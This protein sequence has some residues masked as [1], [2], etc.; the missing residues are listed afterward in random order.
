MVSRASA[1]VTGGAGFIGSHLVERLAGLGLR[2]AVAD[3]LSTGKRENLPTQAKFYPAS[4]T[5]PDLDRV[6]EAEKPSIV[7]HNAAQISVSVS[8]R[9]PAKD[10]ETNVLGILRVLELCRRYKVEKLVFSST[11]GALY[12][13]P[14]YLPCDEGHPINA[15]SPYGTSKYA[16]EQYMELYGRIH[17]LK[18]VALR[19]GN[20]YGPRQDPHG[21]AGVVAIFA[22]M[23]LAG[24]QPTIF[25]DGLQERDFVYVDDV[26]EANIL[27]MKPGI[28][29]HYNI[30]TGNGVNVNRV[31]KILSAALGYKSEA[32]Y[33]PPRPGDVYKI[34][35]DAS[36]ARRELG[37]SPK[38]GIDDGLRRTAD[39]FRKAV[40]VQARV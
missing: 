39:F 29:G 16:G 19:Y 13:E 22:S 6:F 33:G 10:A 37:W 25:G 18:S 9:E 1:L 27:A 23:M 32:K 38:V 11:G 28:A 24:K 8:V 15:L 14:E 3:D 26:V 31:Y 5:S 12:G 4:I 34:A 30:G 35:L 40:G 7:F 20:V 2:V 36:K 17:G 21:E